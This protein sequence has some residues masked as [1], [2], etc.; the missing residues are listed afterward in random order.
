MI[1]TTTD[2][3]VLTQKAKNGL[4]VGYLYRGVFDQHEAVAALQRWNTW[5]DSPAAQRGY[6]LSMQIQALLAK[7]QPIP[8]EIGEELEK[9]GPAK[10]PP[11]LEVLCDW[12]GPVEI[13]PGGQYA[14]GN[15]GTTWRQ[16]KV[17]QWTKTPKL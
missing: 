14:I 11:Y 7:R 6:H 9:I 15:D 5:A 17:G 16:G 13:L 4:F 12:D 3:I 8:D 10:P 2:G 1:F